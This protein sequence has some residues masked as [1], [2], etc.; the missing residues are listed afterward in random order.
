METHPWLYKI[1]TLFQKGWTIKVSN[2]CLLILD[3][4]T[5]DC[6]GFPMV[7][8]WEKNIYFWVMHYRYSM[9][10]FKRG[11]CV[12]GT[13]LPEGAVATQSV[14]LHSVCW[15]GWGM[16]IA[17]EVAPFH[18]FTPCFVGK[19]PLQSIGASSPVCFIM[20]CCCISGNLFLF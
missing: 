19:W 11:P 15:C 16:C 10:C 6:C 4:N 12:F 5:V 17:D 20:S 18:F 1:F 3:V 9:V 14:L 7:W 13:G 2:D 8:K